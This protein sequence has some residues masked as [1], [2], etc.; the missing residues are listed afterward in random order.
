MATLKMQRYRHNRR[1]YGIIYTT[2]SGRK[3]YL[4]T[5]KHEEIFRAGEKTIAD[6]RRKGVASW[7]IDEDTLIYM[8]ALGVQ[9]IGV[10]CKTT[11]AKYLTSLG[12]FYDRSLVQILNFAA[13]GG[14]LQRYMPLQHF[15]VT[16]GK[17]KL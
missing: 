8:R 2:P 3:A 10:H 1:N 7:A 5:R 14:A 12:H 9:F 17:I 16:P 4:A 13:R 11:G 15:R 6:A